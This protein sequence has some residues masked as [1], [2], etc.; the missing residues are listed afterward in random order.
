MAKALQK[1]E[2]SISGTSRERKLVCPVCGRNVPIGMEDCPTCHSNLLL[3]GKHCDKD[4]RKELVDFLQEVRGIG[5]STSQNFIDNGYRCI[6][7]ILDEDI[8][9]LSD[10][11][12]ISD[13]VAQRVKS[14]AEQ[15]VRSIRAAVDIEE[16][17]TMFD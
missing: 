14:K 17:L 3:Q 15:R 8:S 7:D 11:R 12:Y 5:E 10:I 2:D 6:G 1:E 16:L 4:H 9:D 13:D